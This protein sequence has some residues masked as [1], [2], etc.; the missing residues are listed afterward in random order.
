M[1][2]STVR[3][4]NEVK[5]NALTEI[6]R[7]RQELLLLRRG[8]AGSSSGAGR[9]KD[10]ASGLLRISTSQSETSEVIIK[11]YVYDFVYLYFVFALKEQGSKKTQDIN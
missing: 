5:Q 3:A 2:T 6:S 11:Y 7:A 9:D 8:A 1:Q 4:V 10:T